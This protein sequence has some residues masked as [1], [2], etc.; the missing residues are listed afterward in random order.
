MKNYDRAVAKAFREAKKPFPFIVDVVQH[1]DYVELR[2]YE[3]EILGLSDM[4]RLQVMEYLT[5]AQ[6]IIETFQIKVH[7]GGAEGDPPRGNAKR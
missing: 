3:N 2:V 1:P 5:L 6:S 4:Q 7:L